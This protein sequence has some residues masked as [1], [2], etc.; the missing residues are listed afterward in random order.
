AKVFAAPMQTG[1]GL[2][3]KLLEAMAM[4]MP[5]VTTAIANDSLHADPEKEILVG[6]T[7]QAFA[8]HIVKLL[9]S[10]ELRDT[11]AR[12]G[13]QFVH[14]HFSWEQSCEKLSEVLRGVCENKR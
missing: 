10:E 5:C 6:N 2:Q 7:P 1:S 8:D 14:Q 3:N 9:E 13:N 12:N 11:I 4:Q